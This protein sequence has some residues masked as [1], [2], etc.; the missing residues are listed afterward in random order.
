MASEVIEIKLLMGC[1][2]TIGPL[3]VSVFF[4][5]PTYEGLVVLLSV[6]DVVL[7][8]VPDDVESLSE[9][10]PASVLRVILGLVSHV[11]M[12]LIVIELLE[13]TRLVV[14]VCVNIRRVIH[15]FVIN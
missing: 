7:P 4:H 14:V 10:V 9:H 11:L 13:K 2:R 12:T 8:R 6:E 5:I 1:I 3:A 15:I